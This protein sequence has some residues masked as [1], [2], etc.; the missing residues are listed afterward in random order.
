MIEKDKYQ[1]MI[2]SEKRKIN[3]ELYKTKKEI[4]NVC[5]SLILE[6]LI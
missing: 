4:E 3:A 5:F 1:K 2:E 6:Y